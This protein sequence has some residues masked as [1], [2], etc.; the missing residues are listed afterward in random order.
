MAGN[1]IGIIAQ[2]LV[3]RLCECKEMKPA[4]AEECKLLDVDPTNPPQIGH[5]KGCDNCR[6]SGYRGR[7]ALI[8]ILP[9]G[10]EVDELVIQDAPLTQVKKAAEKIGFIPLVSDASTKILEGQ[11]SLSAA[12]KIVDFTSRML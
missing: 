4:T 11:T 6:R 9:F 7:L 3:R 8:E 2:R 10:E 12:M 1:I 5:P